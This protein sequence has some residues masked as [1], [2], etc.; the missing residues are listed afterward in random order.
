[1]ELDNQEKLGIDRNVRRGIEQ[2]RNFQATD[3]GGA[4]IDFFILSSPR[5]GSTFLRLNLGK[6]PGIH[7]LPETHFFGFVRRHRGL[8][9]GNAAERTRIIDA[10][11]RWPQVKR[12]N[13]PGLRPHLESGATA[14]RALLDITVAAHLDAS[15]IDRARVRI[16]EKS[17]PHIHAQ[18]DLEA[19]YP[20]AK[21]VYLVR[22]PRAVV[23]SLKTCDW[24]TSNVVTNARVWRKGVRS[25]GARPDHITVQYEQ[26]IGAPEESMMK[27][28]R[29]LDVDVV[30]PAVFRADTTDGITERAPTSRHSLQPP[31]IAHVHKWRGM[32]SR[33]DR[34]VEVIEAIC[35]REME[36]WG[37]PLEGRARDVRFYTAFATSAIGTAMARFGRL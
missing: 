17:P 21:V 10:W 5:S 36:A 30:D 26:L 32:L 15:G 8:R 23:A 4:M 7:T 33:P 13:V 6:V 28:C 18:T 19:M 24:S 14:F 35:A 27:I 16:G 1:M 31:S 22:D 25:V 11:L 2:I 29:F 34:D 12:L 20:A 9:F 3:G 37:Y